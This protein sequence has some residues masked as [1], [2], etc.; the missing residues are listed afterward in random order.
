MSHSRRPPC[1]EGKPTPVGAGLP[2]RLASILLVVT[3]LTG[4]PLRAEPPGPAAAPSMLR[5][6]A[7]F[8]DDDR[9]TEAEFASENGLPLAAVQ[10]RFAA[11]GT[12]F[13]GQYYASGNLTVADN[14]VATAAHAFASPSCSFVLEPDACTFT[15]EKGA[16]RQTVKIKRIVSQG[17]KC[18]AQPTHFD[19]WA[20]AELAEPIKDV[21][22]YRIE[23]QE[24]RGVRA[25]EDVIFIAALATD[26]RRRDARG[27]VTWPKT[28]GRC[29][30]ENVT[31]GPDRADQLFSSNCDNSIGSSGGAVVRDGSEPALIGVLSFSN[32]TNEMS[33]QAARS[34]RL[35]TGPFLEGGWG[36]YHVPVTGEFWETLRRFAR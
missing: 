14:I 30:V 2:G 26:F 3:C 8:D 15:V 34:G 28:I 16:R 9:R 23:D 13:C 24:R 36:A 10:E 6:V 19:D 1:S 32:E 31:A 25:G 21:M 11:T 5:P 35:N 29:S 17:Y 7:I 12:I 20:V 18:P 4:E 27:E 33:S 22:P